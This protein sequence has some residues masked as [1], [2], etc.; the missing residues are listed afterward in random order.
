MAAMKKQ[1]KGTPSQYLNSTE[2]TK[3][4]IETVKKMKN[5]EGPPP[6]IN[7]ADDTLQLLCDERM[8]AMDFFG[9]IDLPVPFSPPSLT[10]QSALLTNEK[11]ATEVNI[12][13]EEKLAAFELLVDAYMKQRID[14]IHM[15]LRDFG[16]RIQSDLDTNDQLE[17]LFGLSNIPD[18][19]IAYLQKRMDYVKKFSSLLMDA[20]TRL[21][22]E[23]R[24]LRSELPELDRN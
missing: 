3:H 24:V 9:D 19:G 17:S 11:I 20:N 13:R 1:K 22:H 4:I 18:T 8:N 21:S 15:C 12:D 10:Y 5:K 16:Q 2:D 23:C 14:H 6:P 7:P